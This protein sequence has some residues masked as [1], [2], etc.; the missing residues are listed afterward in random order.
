M[1]ELKLAIRDS[2]RNSWNNL[3]RQVKTD[4]WGLPYKLVTKKLVGRRPIP[5]LSAPGR[6]KSIVDA[7]F[8][9]EEP[10]V[11]PLRTGNHDFPAVTNAEITELSNKIPRGKAPG[12]DGV[13]D[14]IIRNVARHKPEILRDIFNKCLK[15]SVFSH[16][17]KT[18]KLVLLRNRDKPLEDPSS[19]R[20]ICLLNTVGKFFERLIKTRIEKR[21]GFR[22]GW[23]T[24]DAIKRVQDVVEAAG[25]RQPYNRKLCA[26]VALDVA[27][28]FN[29]QR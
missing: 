7:L 22:K 14:L 6:V 20:P 16:S 3:C 2:K 5:G 17:R 1:K 28:A 23:S 4:P 18:A 27:N 29:S 13:P 11:W 24:V 25:S 8:P 10:T 19:Y 26:V 21:L 12:P 15:G 9:R